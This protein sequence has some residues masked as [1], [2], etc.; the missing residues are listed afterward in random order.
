MI[1]FFRNDDV[2]GRVDESLERITQ[3]FIDRGIPIVM[4]VEPGN[5][6][7]PVAGWLL[8]KQDEHPGIIEIMQH[9]YD[10]TIKNKYRKGEFG[11]QRGY[12]EQ[13]REIEAGMKLMHRFFGER[14]FWAFNFP[15]GPY[16]GPAIRALDDLGFKVFNSHYNPRLSRRA[17]YV[18]GRLLRRGRLLGRHVSWHLNRYPGTN[19]L[20][21]DVSISFIR[22]YIDENTSCEFESLSRLIAETECCRRLPVVGVLLHHR[23]HATEDSI[24]L[25][26]RYLDWA[27]AAGY[28][29]CTL[30]QVY[31]E[32]ATKAGVSMRVGSV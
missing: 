31:K 3:L 13:R 19:L 9:G 16:N 20:E 30:E 26:A 8:K 29:F 10:H 24:E 28:R 22:R 27:K 6:S 25:V 21:V 2:R 7:A 4:A 11:G 18:V 17:F 14:W 12:D 1:M 15:F 23:Y 32:W 5:V